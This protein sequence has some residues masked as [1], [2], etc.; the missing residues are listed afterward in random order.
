M[1]FDTN[2]SYSLNS[3]TVNFLT[4][5]NAFRGRLEVE[6]TF[7]VTGESVFEANTYLRKNVDVKESLTTKNFKASG[8]TETEDV[9]ING[10]L[11]VKGDRIL[12]YEE[13][14]VYG[15]LTVYD[16]FFLGNTSTKSYMYSTPGQNIG[17][18]KLNANSTLDVSGTNSRS[19]SVY[20]GKPATYNI[21][22]RNV[23]NQGMS[24]YSNATVTQIGFYG[25]SKIREQDVSTSLLSN[26]APTPDAK[27]QYDL[28]S[29]SLTLDVSDNTNI[30]S[31][32]SIA[33]NTVRRTAH[34]YN[35]TMV[36]YGNTSTS[37]YLWKSLEN[38]NMN[39]SNVASFVSYDNS[40]NAFLNIITPNKQGVAIGGGKYI[41]DASRAFGTIGLLDARGE[42]YPSMNLVEGNS[43]MKKRFTLG[44]NKHAP[45]VDHYAVDMNGPLRINNGEHIVSTRTNFEIRTTEFSRTMPNYAIAIGTPSNLNRNVLD[46]LYEYFI[47]YTTDSCETWKISNTVIRTKNY[48]KI[49]D[50]CIVNNNLSILVGNYGTVYYS[51]TAQNNDYPNHE[52]GANWY[53]L[54]IIFRIGN[55]II[56]TPEDYTSVYTSDAGRIFISQQNK[57]I[58][59]N[60][61]T[62]FGSDNIY[63]DI[64][65]I[66]IFFNNDERSFDVPYITT[67]T[68][69][70]G[71]GTTM[72]VIGENNIL[73]YTNIN[74]TPTLENNKTHTNPYGVYN[75]IFIY[76]TNTAIAVG[77][78]IISFT[79]NGGTTWSDAYTAYNLNSA[80]IYD[81]YTAMIVG[82]NGIILYLIDYSDEQ[83]PTWSVVSPDT[84]NASGI[85]NLL[86]DPLCDL[87]NIKMYD[88]NTF[89]VTKTTRPYIEPNGFVLGTTITDPNVIGQLGN[90]SVIYCTYPYIFNNVQNFVLDVSGSSRYSGDINID[91]EGKIASTNEIFYLLNDNVKHIFFGNDASSVY[92][93]SRF[94]S[95]T[96]INHDFLVLHNSK[97]NGTL[98]VDGNVR[99]NQ[100]LYVVGDTTLHSNVYVNKNEFIDESLYVIKDVSLGIDLTVGRNSHMYGYLVVD[101]NATIYSNATV[102][103]NTYCRDELRVYHNA[104]FNQKMLVE[105]NVLMMS[106]LQVVGDVSMGSNLDVSLNTSVYG[107]LWVAGNTDISSNLRVDVDTSI[108]RDFLVERNSR[109]YGTLDVSKNTSVYGNMYVFGNTDISS[110]LRVDID[111]SIGRDFLVERNSRLYGTLDVSK[112]TSVYG[113]MYVLG[114]TDI[115]SNLRVDV[116][117]SIGRDLLVEKNALIVQNTRVGGNVDIL[118]NATIINDVSMG[119]NLTVSQQSRLKGNV[120]VD[121]FL[122]TPLLAVTDTAN[123]ETLNVNNNATFY[124]NAYMNYYTQISGRFSVYSAMSKIYGNVNVDLDSVFQSNLLIKQNANIENKLYVLQNAYFSSNVYIQGDA[125]LNS[126]LYVNRDTNINRD[127]NIVRN[128]NINKNLFVNEETLLNGNVVVNKAVTANGIVTVNN[129]LKAMYYESLTYGGNIY[130]GYNTY[131]YTPVPRNIFISGGNSYVPQNNIQIGSSLDTVS[132]IGNTITL[133]NTDFLAVNIPKLNTGNIYLNPISSAQLNFGNE[134]VSQPGFIRFSTDKNGYFFGVP[135]YSKIVNLDVGSMTQMLPQINTGVVTISPT[136]SDPNSNFKLSVATIDVS[137]ILLK[138]YSSSDLSLNIQI[139][140]TSL[141]ILG[142]AYVLQHMAIGKTTA[143]ANISLDV[144]G[145]ISQKSGGFIRQF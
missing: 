138:K 96:Q 60:I 12:N 61:S 117:T 19:L 125:S 78:N 118:G 137:N 53:G 100:Q 97:L 16:T 115:S 25:N 40:T 140:D 113:N 28:P 101:G 107:N 139:I 29:G 64:N 14:E 131:N 88:V 36:V 54:R 102:W 11:T 91:N 133:G 51:N 13:V 70:R 124:S 50:I 59:M 110:N 122:T 52:N 5:I 114:N 38:T 8:F 77:N 143:E 116:D 85:A 67:I 144:V 95:L 123:I 112:N 90:S 20:S 3:L 98:I 99:F 4:L 89:L 37:P 9:V 75:S 15:N 41:Y 121:V 74:G 126:N 109:L 73:K 57:I 142:N 132:V 27:I 26:I 7:N 83:S 134:F 46:F 45:G 24:V 23:N 130:I 141:G 49:N 34:P 42:Y 10:N 33:P 106:H 65:G 63:T 94:N 93:A 6:G 127:A 22:S 79:K 119:G 72:Y 48:T 92:I 128:V 44:I 35:E 66:V 86:I 17:I 68:K 18:N 43:R 58:Y 62:D 71:I 21:L 87:T 129:T 136:P 32:V 69:I 135:N 82:K 111:T 108:G 145:D 76:D 55:T 104:T 84:L 103:G 31:K 47:T 80:Y 30:L 56:S 39:T 2:A 105:G 81:L 120:T 1:S